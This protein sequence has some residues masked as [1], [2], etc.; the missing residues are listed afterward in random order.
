MFLKAKHL[1]R[2]GIN[3]DY[4]CPPSHADMVKWQCDGSQKQ[5]YPPFV[6]CAALIAAASYCMMRTSGISSNSMDKTFT[7]GHTSVYIEHHPTN[8]LQMKAVVCWQVTVDTT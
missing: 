6:V 7:C 1:S 2:N 8:R 5:L 4:N 3:D